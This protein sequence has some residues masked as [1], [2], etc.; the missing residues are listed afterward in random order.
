MK[1]SNDDPIKSLSVRFNDER[2]EFLLNRTRRESKLDSI[3]KLSV[4]P[5]R[6]RKSSIAQKLKPFGKIV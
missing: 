6:K 5:N 3:L 4:Q 1:S 2:D